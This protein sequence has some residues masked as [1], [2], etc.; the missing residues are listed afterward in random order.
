MKTGMQVLKYPRAISRRTA[1]IGIAAATLFATHGPAVAQEF[2]NRAITIVCPFGPGT[3]IDIIGRQLAQYMTA[4]LGQSVI[5]DNRAGATGNIATDYVAKSA[6]NGYTIY[7]TSTSII[8]NQ[9]VGAPASSLAKDFEPVAISGTLPYA[10]LVPTSLPAQNLQELV[11]LAKARPGKLNYAGYVGGVPQFLGEMLNRAANVNI[12]MVPYKSTT[13]AA[14][15]FVTDRI[16]VLFTPVPS[17][18]PFQA[19]KQGRVIAVTGEK[20]A[21]ILPD[22]PTMRE[23]GFPDLTVEVGY[24]FLAPAGT[25]KPIVERLS[26]AIT[27][28]LHDPKVWAALAAQGVEKKEGGPDETRTYLADELRKWEGIVKQSAAAA[29]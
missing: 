22:V 16:Q 24:F 8:V 6:P 13:D 14:N 28:G 15:D 18:L 12:V 23:A 3:A 27:N 25:P 5:V 21:T 9:F 1:G 10:V 17:G 29:K 26:S 4:T 11:A 19:G 2:P 20:R 7:I